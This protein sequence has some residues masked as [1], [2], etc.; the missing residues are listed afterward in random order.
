MYGHVRGFLHQPTSR[1][2]YSLRVSRS[3]SAVKM[4]RRVLSLRL[5]A[6]VHQSGI[7]PLQVSILHQTRLRNRTRSRAGCFRA[8]RGEHDKRDYDTVSPDNYLISLVS[9]RAIAPHCQQDDSLGDRRTTGSARDNSHRSSIRRSP[10]S[11]R[12]RGLLSP[13][14]VAAAVDA[15]QGQR[16]TRRQPRIDVRRR[17]G[18]ERRGQVPAQLRARCVR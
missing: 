4:S 2:A 18:V 5:D 7:T 15:R 8:R 10:E 11:A 16:Q 3:C 1:P 9:T 17:L 6:I 12:N 13:A 14:P